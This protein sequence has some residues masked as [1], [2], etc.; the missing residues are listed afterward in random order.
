MSI[1]LY[2]SGLRLVSAKVY[3]VITL[4]A[5]MAII[6]NHCTELKSAE[7][8]YLGFYFYSLK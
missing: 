7:A 4:L 5:I 8:L 6:T 3:K 1:H 2:L